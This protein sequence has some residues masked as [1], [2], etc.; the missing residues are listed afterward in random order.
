S[1]DWPTTWGA[2]RDVVRTLLILPSSAQAAVRDVADAFRLIGL[3]SSQWP[4][5]V[6]RHGEDSFYVDTCLGFGLAPA[7]GVWGLVADAIAD[8]C[9]AHGH[10]PILKWVDDFLFL[11]VPLVAIADVN[12]ARSRTASS[13]VGKRSR[14]GVVFFLGEDGEEHVE[15]YHFPLR[16][17]SANQPHELISSLASISAV[18]SP[19]GAPWKE[20]KDVD[21]CGTP[22]YIGFQWHI[23]ER[24][25]ALPT[26]KRLKYLAA[27]SDWQHQPTHS[28]Q[29]AQKLFGKLQHASFVVAQGR[30]HLGSLCAFVAT[31]APVSAWISH[32]A[33]RQVEKDLAWW[34][35]ALSRASLR[36]SFLGDDVFDNIYVACDASTSYGIGIYVDG[37]ELSLPVLP[38]WK[39]QGRDIAWLEAVALEIAVQVIVSEGIADCRVRIITDNT[40]VFFSER[41]GHSR[42]AAVTSVLARIR[43]IEALYNIEVVPTLV[44]SAQ[45]MADAPSRGLRSTS[46]R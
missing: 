25:V 42:N 46:A 14:G 15:D 13:I 21:F 37:A 5:T 18:T 31:M 38:G 43:D 28:L 2:A 26:A 27:I 1:D 7:T 36:R 24:C 9:R 8:I 6:V 20:V 30:K 41:S 34:S 19:L 40:S 45:N 22:I 32:R 23:E 44:P 39:G 33:S 4:G 10:G 12:L 11:S 29:S 35:S 16:N 17:H 3:H